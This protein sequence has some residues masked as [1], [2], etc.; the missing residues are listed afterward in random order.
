MDIVFPLSSK[1]TSDEAGIQIKLSKI[2]FYHG[3]ANQN[4]GFAVYM[5]ICSQCIRVSKIIP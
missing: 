4:N 3:F 5:K 1:F 2:V